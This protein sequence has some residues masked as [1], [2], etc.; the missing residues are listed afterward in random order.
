MY[1]AQTY[2]ELHALQRLLCLITLA[3]SVT[4]PASASADDQR[5]CISND[6]DRMIRGCTAIVDDG[7]ETTEILASAYNNRGL[8]YRHKGEY[9]RAI[10][11]YDQAI[12]LNPSYAFAYSN[13]AWAY[14]KWGKASEALSDANHALKLG[15]D[16]AIIL[17]TRAHIFEALGRNQDAIT[18]FR[19]ALVLH[20]WMQSSK[21]GL[22]RLGALP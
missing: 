12:K 20:P 9:D 8:A 17:D 3:I 5:D 15:P 7:R 10:G 18:D 1:H 16:N 14:L 21:A 22:K 19:R 6:P 4:W 11:D 2:L 13:R